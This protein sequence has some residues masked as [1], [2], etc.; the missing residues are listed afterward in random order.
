MA[1]K[2]QLERKINDLH[3]TRRRQAEEEQ[4]KKEIK[5]KR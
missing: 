4:E 2:L 3:E 1:Q 5:V